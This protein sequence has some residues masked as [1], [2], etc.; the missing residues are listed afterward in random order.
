MILWVAGDATTRIGEVA[1]LQT[2]KGIH[3]QSLSLFEPS[4]RPSCLC[5]E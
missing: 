2:L 5:W 3:R 1:R 4:N